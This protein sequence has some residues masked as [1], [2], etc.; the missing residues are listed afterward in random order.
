VHLTF[1]IE[2]ISDEAQDIDLFDKPVSWNRSESFQ[3]HENLE[4]M[5]FDLL[6]IT[7]A[8]VE[9]DSNWHFE[10]LSEEIDLFRE[11]PDDNRLGSK[12]VLKL[13]LHKYNIHS[14]NILSFPASL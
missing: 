2:L 9:E 13:F 8:L 4:S 6:K 5:P 11:L 7:S 14:H 10:R 3:P 12:F 1:T